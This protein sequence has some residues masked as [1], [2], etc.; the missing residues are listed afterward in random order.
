[1]RLFIFFFIFFSSLLF[2]QNIF[3]ISLD[4]LSSTTFFALL[5]KGKLP[6]I[7]SLIS[8]GNARKLAKKSF[9]NLAFSHENLLYNKGLKEGA[10]NN[11]S[12][13]EVV[14]NSF[15]NM[16]TLMLLSAPK[17][18]E[19][20]PDKHEFFD[21]ARIED[22]FNK[23]QIASFKRRSSQEIIQKLLIVLETSQKPFFVYFNMPQSAHAAFKTR[24]GS[25][26]YS[27]VAQACDRSLKSL[28]DFLI[29]QNLLDSSIFIFTS[30]MTFKD[31][32]RQFSETTWIA[33][34][35]KTK[36]FGMQADIFPTI[37]KELGID[38]KDL[39]PLN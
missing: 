14:K 19:E 4:G 29:S 28:K 37:L 30:S 12:L 39:T 18:S 16:T 5:Q 36:K 15:P 21:L 33:S 9:S 25:A 11:Q 31:K 3:Y 8:Q 17:G 32:S 20:M 34:S 27:Q 26:Y 10:F 22:V 7:S 35:F 38:C 13:M 1:M 6:T 2:S 24:E 23:V